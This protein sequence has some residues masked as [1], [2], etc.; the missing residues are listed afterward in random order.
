MNKTKNNL[1][2]PKGFVFSGVVA[3]IKISGAPDLALALAPEGASAAALFTTNRVVAAPVIAGRAN[4]KASRGRMR[5]VVVNSGNANCATGK[6]GLRASETICREL[7]K[8]LKCRPEEIFPSSTGVIGVP[9]P[10]DRVLKAMP[11]LLDARGESSGHA[12]CFARAIMTT[13]TR[14]KSACASFRS[15][16]QTVSLMG[17]AKGAGMIHPKLATMLVYLFTDA[18]ATPAQLRPMLAKA[19]GESFNRISI[20]GDTSTNDTALLLASGASGVDVSKPAERTR[21]VAVLADVCQSLA[22]Q[23]VAD[24]EG[25]QHV[26]ALKIEQAKS[27][28]EAEQVARAIANSPL[29]KTAWA[30]AD[31]NWGRVLAAV[32]YSGVPIDPARVSIFFGPHAVCRNG[33]K[34]PFDENQVHSYLEQPELEIG[35]RLGRGR[36]SAT[37]WTCDLSVEYVKINAEYRT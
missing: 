11:A 7:A 37:F 1:Q 5:A 21:F 6:T 30:G 17:V 26:V 34:A 16:G 9:L 8:L 22:K 20:D 25:V 24:G 18:K 29:V 23:I 2:V 35:V 27:E 33:E 32:G 3:G 28:A 13:D 31:P 36:A 12:E 4:L 14:L 15:G 19:C 10:I